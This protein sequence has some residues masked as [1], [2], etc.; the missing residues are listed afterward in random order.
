MNRYCR[1]VS[2]LFKFQNIYSIT[3]VETGM[4][5]HFT[6]IKKPDGR[7]LGGSVLDPE[8]FD[9]DPDPNPTL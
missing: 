8:S 2:K 7:T 3:G 5:S 4:F 6:F 9:P 1:V